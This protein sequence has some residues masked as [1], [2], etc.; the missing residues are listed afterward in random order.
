MGQ[1]KDTFKTTV[2]FRVFPEGDV[3]ALFPMEVAD[4]HGNIMSYMKIGQH[5]AA[6]PDLIKELKVATLKQ[7]IPLKTELE[8]IGY[9]L[10]L[11]H[12]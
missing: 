9:T 3:I 12:V 11:S 2:I 1:P 6:S 7:L 5:G 10:E 4:P 8:N